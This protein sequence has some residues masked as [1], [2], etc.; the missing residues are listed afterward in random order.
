MY[1]SVFRGLYNYGKKYIKSKAITEATETSARTINDDID[2]FAKDWLDIGNLN[3]GEDERVREWGNQDKK[4][5]PIPERKP[6]TPMNREVSSWSEEDVEEIMKT[7][8]YQFDNSTQK[9][10]QSYFDYN[11]PGNVEY[12]AT[13]RMLP[14]KKRRP[15]L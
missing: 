3:E 11:Y 4:T 13:G 1:K 8:A 6:Q 10:V 5:I 12:D 14:A 7:K 15:F 2:D 9:K